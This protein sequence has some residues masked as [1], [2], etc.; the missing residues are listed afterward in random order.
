MT[1]NSKR[2]KNFSPLLDYISEVK[3]ITVHKLSTADHSL[4]RGGIVSSLLQHA[5]LLVKDLSEQC[6]IY[7]SGHSPASS[8]EFSCCFTTLEIKQEWSN[9]EHSLLHLALYSIVTLIGFTLLF[10][11]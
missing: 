2:E 1:R 3:T 4:L 5:H 6:S 9:E 11:Q 8:T 10:A 7:K